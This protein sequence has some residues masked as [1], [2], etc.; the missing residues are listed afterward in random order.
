MIDM[1]LLKT[2]DRLGK[3]R[4]PIRRQRDVVLS[5]LANAEAL[6]RRADLLEEQAVKAQKG[7]KRLVNKS[8]NH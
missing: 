8:S 6:R 7:L 3:V 1:E 5:L 2:V 4:T